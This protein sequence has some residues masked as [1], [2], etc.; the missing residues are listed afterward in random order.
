M[1]MDWQGWIT[2]G[3]V[4]TVAMTG[5]MVAAQLIGLSRMDLPL[6]LGTMITDRPE[7]ARSAGVVIHLVNGQI[8]ALLYASAFAS[9]GRATWW[10]GLGF[11]VL[12]GTAALTVL[13]PL[14][15][16]VHPHMSTE[17]SG[18]ALAVASL[19]PPGPVAINYGVQTPV[20]TL[21]AH[22]V[23]GLMLGAFLGP[24]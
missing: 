7:R 4:A 1:S 8:F 23:Y 12:H 11:G 14:F 19:E 21:L 6:L 3:F 24:R 18:P 10:M 2:F 22:A 9:I 13:L 17:R 16:G 20:V 5:M 15:A